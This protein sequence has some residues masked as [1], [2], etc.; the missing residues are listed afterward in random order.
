MCQLSTATSATKPAF[1]AFQCVRKQ[2]IH[3]LELFSD[4]FPFNLEL[5]P[6]QCFFSEELGAA[7]ILDGG[8]VPAENAGEICPGVAIA[9]LGTD[10]HGRGKLMESGQARKG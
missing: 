5:I 7:W 9:S 1:K 10:C 8:I 4:V 2:L 3:L 6:I